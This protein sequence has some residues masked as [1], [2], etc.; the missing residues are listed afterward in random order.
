MLYIYD[1]IYNRKKAQFANW[2][3]KK[4]DALNALI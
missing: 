2:M 3:L 4:I 1:N